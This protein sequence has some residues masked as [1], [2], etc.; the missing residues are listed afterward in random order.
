MRLSWLAH[1]CA[2]ALASPALAVDAGRIDALVDQA[3]ANGCVIADAG[4]ALT[5][6]GVADVGAQEDILSALVTRDKAARFG[7]AVLL[8]PATCHAGD[9]PSRHDRFLAVMGQGG[10][11]AQPL[12]GLEQRMARY[13]LTPRDVTLL[14]DEMIRH[15]E[16]SQSETHLNV[17]DAFCDQ[18]QSLARSVVPDARAAF[19]SF[20]AAH[21]CRIGTRDLAGAVTT[22]GLDPA[23]TDVVVEALVSRG[24]AIYYGFDKTLILL[25][26]RCT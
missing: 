17:T 5:G 14:R 7:S 3:R 16:L 22:A 24:E 25:W 8:E 12:A 10:A 1:I 6:A 15:G 21:D 11:C 4:A 20:M 9:V 26:D 18:A 19:V 2:F 13:A 23:A